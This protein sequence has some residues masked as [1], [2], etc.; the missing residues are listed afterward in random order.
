MNIP[1]RIQVPFESQLLHFQSIFPADSPGLLANDDPVGGP[2]GVRCSWLQP[3]LSLI[4]VVIW[5]MN[6]WMTDL[7]LC[8]TLPLPRPLCLSH[9]SFFFFLKK[10]R[11]TENGIFLL[12]INSPDG[13]RGQD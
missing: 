4:V 9:I 5:E 1:F 8:P 12:L 10:G 11:V 7:S 3:G 13:H 2:G 6:Q